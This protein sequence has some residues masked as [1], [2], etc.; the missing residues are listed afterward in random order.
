MNITKKF[1]FFSPSSS[2]NTLITTNLM[3]LHQQWKKEEKIALLQ[4]THFPDVHTFVEGNEKR[5]ILNLKHLIDQAESDT[6]P[7]S[8]IFPSPLWNDWTELSVPDVQNILSFLEEQYD[9]I[10][11][12]LHTSV[13]EDIVEE[14]LRNADKIILPINITPSHLASVESFFSKYENLIPKCSLIFNQCPSRTTSL[15]KRKF[16]GRNVE[17]LG[18]LPVAKKYLWAQLFE[19]IPIVFRRKS[20]WKKAL[21][22]LLQKLT[23]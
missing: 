7:P 21:F 23:Q 12:D 18:A 10:Y 15:I 16:K 5:T 8:Q 22:K 19:A 3:L 17:I 14:V 1:V 20:K 9:V 2:G 4:L 6:Y 11:I 13:E